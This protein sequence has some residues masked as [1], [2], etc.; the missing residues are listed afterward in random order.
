M[1]QALCAAGAGQDAEGY[2]GLPEFGAAGRVENVA[3]HGEFAAAAEGV[4]GDGSQERC[5][6]GGYCRSPGGEIG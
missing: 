3:E 2:F 4:A 1:G 6:E 5:A